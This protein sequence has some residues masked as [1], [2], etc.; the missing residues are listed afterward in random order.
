MR[1]TTAAM[2][3]APR[4]S[5][6]FGSL[7]KSW[8]AR[9]GLSQLD[10][11]LDTGVSQRHLSFLE[12]GRARPSRDMVLHLGGALGLPLRHQNALLLAAGFAPVYGARDLA[13]PEMAEVN[14]ALDRILAQQEPFPALVVDRGLAVLRANGA[15]H[16]LLGFL[17]E[18]APPAP[19][20]YLHLL[21]SPEGIRPFV[22]N[23]DEVVSFL[24][25]RHKAES[26]ID[27]EGGDGALLPEALKTYPGVAELARS[28]RGDPAPAPILS[29][30]FRKGDVALALFT[31]ITTL[32]TPLDVTL[33]DIR[34]EAFF[35]SDAATERFFR[36]GA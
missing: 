29:V 14:A 34:I 26:L 30:R 25:H 3:G 9:R 31:T 20:N 11:A 4:Q 6:P 36:A 24:L 13:G 16:R 35:P 5:P 33:Q 2:T 15:A 18:R 17:L 1:S 8:R 27:G 21:L 23:W 7:L 12:S 28:L 10:C 19:A 32:G 22:E